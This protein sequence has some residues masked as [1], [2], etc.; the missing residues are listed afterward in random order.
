MITSDHIAAGALI[1]LIDNQLRGINNSISLI[2]HNL[3][4][5]LSEYYTL[6][7][8]NCI[9]LYVYV[10]TYL[11]VKYVRFSIYAQY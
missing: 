6:V 8:L 3:R 2:L 7:C 10:P 5:L 9:T 1:S 11:L 4:H